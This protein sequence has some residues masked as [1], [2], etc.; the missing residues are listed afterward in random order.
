MGEPD[1]AL[2][3]PTPWNLSCPDW[4]RRLEDGQSL[5][6]ALP[7]DRVRADRAVAVF[8]KLRIPDVPGTPTMAEA[9]GEWIFEIVGA[10]FGAFDVPTSVRMIRGLFVMVPKKNAKTTYGAAITLTAAILNDRPRA[11][12][13][14][15]A[16]SLEIASKA[17]SQA[18]GMIEL[19]DEGYLQKRFWVRDNIKTIYDRR[20]KANTKIKTFDK[21]IVTGAVPAF[22]LIDEVHL[23]GDDPSAEAVVGQLKGGMMSVPGAFWAM[24]TTQSFK[25]PA[26]VF[27]SELKIARAIR[28]GRAP[29]IDTLPVLYEFSEQQ[30][31][32]KDFWENPAN[33][34]RLQPNIRRSVWVE[35]LAKDF[36]AEKMKDFGAQKIWASQHLN[37]EIG[38]AMHDNRWPG[39]NHWEGAVERTITLAD[40]LERSEVVTMGGDGGGLDDLLGLAV[41]GREKVTRRWLLWTRAWCYVGVL[42]LRQEI[43]PRLRDFDNADEL[44]IIERLGDDMEDAKAIAEEVVASGK[45]PPKNAVGVDP[46]GLAGLADALQQGGVTDEQLVGVSQGWRLSGAI[47]STERAL[48]DGTLVHGGQAMMAWCVGN[49]KIEPRGNAK[50]ITKQ[51]SGTAKIDPLMAAFNAVSLMAMNPQAPNTGS[52]YDDAVAYAKA[53]TDKGEVEPTPED[54]DDGNWKSAILADPDHPLFAEHRRRFDEWQATQEDD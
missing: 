33:W 15:T 4:E 6:P 45:L 11:E 27:K 13:L 16:P 9:A 38:L 23:L 32:A 34:A 47:M 12:L 41:L 42:D 31:K 10:I 14:M 29:G 35:T 50:L 24:I 19:D 3:A 51:A 1:Q 36:A 21:K 30:Q 28:D 7:L 44:R 39:A 17:F 49:A 37:I 22:A 46:A 52:I 8:K 25:E 2:T 26:G 48:A 5:V 40:L 54:D 53:F 20:T 43:A 18:S